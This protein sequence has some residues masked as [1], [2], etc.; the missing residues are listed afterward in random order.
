ML[1]DWVGLEFANGNKRGENPLDV[2]SSPDKLRKF[3]SEYDHH[4]RTVENM[5]KMKETGIDAWISNQKKKGE[6][7][8]CP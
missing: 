1:E 2:N 5:K 4:K 6:L 3:A 7:A 8:F